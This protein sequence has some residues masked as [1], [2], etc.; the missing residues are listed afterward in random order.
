MSKGSLWKVVK[1]PLALGAATVIPLAALGVSSVGALIAFGLSAFTV[2]AIVAE[3]VRGSRVHRRRE[4]LGWGSALVRTMVR[5]RR[6]YGGYVVHLGVVLIV[7]G[8]AGSAF[9]TERQAQLSPGGSME[10]G[11]YTLRYTGAESSET[12]EKQINTAVVEAYRGDDYV[13]TLHPQ[14]NFHFAQE[15]PQSEVAIRTNP[16]ED[17]YVVAQSFDSDDAV[18]LVAFVNP[19]TWWIWA[20]AGV[21]ALGMLVLLSGRAVATS[22]STERARAARPAV[23]TQ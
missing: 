10:V 22:T 3:F 8:F 19:L 9:S 1:V 14:R 11:G 23:V 21:M 15:Q 20:G 13:T 17:L 6:R 7:I 2:S 4:A 5:N 16:I 12:A 18:V